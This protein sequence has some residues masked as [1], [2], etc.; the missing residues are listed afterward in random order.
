MLLLLMPFAG[1]TQ[2][3][4]A[5]RNATE[6]R[7]N[8]LR[9]KGSEALFNLDYEAA[10]QNIQRAVAFFSRRSAWTADDGSDTVVGNLE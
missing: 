9:E 8:E 6:T 3:G 4:N 10:R 5:Q 1:V 7:I 2:S